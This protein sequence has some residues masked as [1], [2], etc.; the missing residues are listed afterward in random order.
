MRLRFR[1][2]LRANEYLGGVRVCVYMRVCVRMCVRF[3]FRIRVC[4]RIHIRARVRERPGS[5]L[6]SQSSTFAFVV[7]FTPAFGFVNRR[8]CF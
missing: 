4:V 7:A 6:R 2:R 5:R 1:L 8:V 3:H